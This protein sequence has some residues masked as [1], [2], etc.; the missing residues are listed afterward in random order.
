[1]KLGRL[2]VFGVGYLLGTKAGR[3]RYEQILAAAQRLSKRLDDYSRHTDPAVRWRGDTG[4]RAY[5]DRTR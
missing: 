1:M 4:S 5:N 2:A 3:E